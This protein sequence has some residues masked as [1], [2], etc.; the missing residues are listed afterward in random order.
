MEHRQTVLQ[1]VKQKIITEFRQ[2]VTG[3]LRAQLIV[4]VTETTAERKPGFKAV[5][6][7]PAK[8]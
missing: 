7:S 6:K 3:Q 5:H 1:G 4:E 8:K 2:T